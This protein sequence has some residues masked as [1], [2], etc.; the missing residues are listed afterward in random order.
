MHR[1][2]RRAAVR[3]GQREQAQRHG[4]HR[5]NAVQV[6]QREPGLS[7]VRS[8]C[9]QFPFMV[10]QN[11]YITPNAANSQNAGGGAAWCPGRA[12]GEEALAY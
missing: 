6:G 5:A 1:P 11:P 4:H 8:S 9:D 10:S 7:E 3:D 12:G 2:G